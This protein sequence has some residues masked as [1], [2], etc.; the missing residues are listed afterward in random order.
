MKYDREETKG[1]D[2]LLAGLAWTHESDAAR[3]EHGMIVFE[4]L[5]TYFLRRKSGAKS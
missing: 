4:A 2:H 3:L 5:Y 1:F